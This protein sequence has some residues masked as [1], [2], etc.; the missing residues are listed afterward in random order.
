MYSYLAFKYVVHMKPSNTSIIPNH[1][2]KQVL[3][4]QP[5]YQQ[6]PWDCVLEYNRIEN[7]LQ[8][9]SQCMAKW[10]NRNILYCTPHKSLN[11]LQSQNMCSWKL[12]VM[13]DFS[14]PLQV[15]L[16]LVFSWPV[17]GNLLENNCHKTRITTVIENAQIAKC[18][19]FRFKYLLHTLYRCYVSTNFC[20]FYNSDTLENFIFGQRRRR[21][22]NSCSFT[23]IRQKRLLFRADQLRWP[24]KSFHVTRRWYPSVPLAL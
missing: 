22:R 5:Y 7:L 11:S 8:W 16:P 17:C 21:G 10:E 12:L 1:N 18:C 13:L 23:N 19:L 20:I 14:C 9:L 6:R 4:S 2:T 24:T 15:N 3:R